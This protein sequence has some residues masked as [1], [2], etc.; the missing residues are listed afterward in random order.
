MSGR[1]RGSPPVKMKMG[2]SSCAISSINFS[3]STVLSSSGFLLGW[4][5]ARQWKHARSQARVTSQITTNGVWF[6]SKLIFMQPIS[7]DG[8]LPGCDG[9]HKSD[10][11]ELLTCHS[12]Y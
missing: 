12:E 1:L 5:D 3:P 11:A 7:G 6:R 2:G 4:A 9:D 8:T 10:Y